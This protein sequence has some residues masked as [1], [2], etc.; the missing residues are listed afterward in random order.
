[1]M[2]KSWQYI[3]EK[4]ETSHGTLLSLKVYMFRRKVGMEIKWKN[5]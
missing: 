4:L 5:N 1:M 2:Q 3:T